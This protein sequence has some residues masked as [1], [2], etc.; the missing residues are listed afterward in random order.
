[1]V[2]SVLYCVPIYIQIRGIKTVCSFFVF[3]SMSATRSRYKDLGLKL[4]ELLQDCFHQPRQ[5]RM[6]E[7]NKDEGEGDPIKL[8]L[9]QS[10]E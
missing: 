4:L 10:L 3:L 5:I 9:E 8:F 7:E 2:I 1:M 6:V